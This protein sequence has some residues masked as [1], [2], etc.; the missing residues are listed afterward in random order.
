[1]IL[2]K[3]LAVIGVCA[4]SVLCGVMLAVVDIKLKEGGITCHLQEKKL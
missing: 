4:V 2:I 3:I 1:M